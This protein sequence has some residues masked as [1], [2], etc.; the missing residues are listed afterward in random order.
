MRVNADEDKT[1]DFFSYSQ[2]TQEVKHAANQ[3]GYTVFLTDLLNF[4]R[5]SNVGCIFE[6]TILGLNF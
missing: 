6:A 1:N 2:S 5:D 3:F 4:F